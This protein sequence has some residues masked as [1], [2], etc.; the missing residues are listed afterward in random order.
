M[1]QYHPQVQKYNLG[2]QCSVHL[3]PC[4]W[5]QSHQKISA[6]ACLFDI[7]MQIWRNSICSFKSYPTYKT[8]V[9]KIFY[10]QEYDLENEVKATKI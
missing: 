10:L 5:D 2:K 9:Q 6:L 8:M 4:K 7:S 1:I 3:W